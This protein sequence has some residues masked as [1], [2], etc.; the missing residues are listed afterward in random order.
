MRF[1]LCA[2][3]AGLVIAS[4]LQTAHPMTGTCLEMD[5]IG[6]TVLG[7]NGAHGGRGRV[8]GLTVGAF[9]IVFWRTAW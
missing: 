3:L 8:F 1:G 2:A 5:A 9:V 7:G 4:Q 6:A